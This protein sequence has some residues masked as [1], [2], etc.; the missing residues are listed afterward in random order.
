MSVCKLGVQK[1][2]WISQSYQFTKDLPKQYPPF[3]VIAAGISFYKQMGFL[4][5]PLLYMRSIMR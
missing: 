2:L 4:R 5:R 1:F 3:L